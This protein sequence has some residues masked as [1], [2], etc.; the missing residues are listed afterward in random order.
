MKTI[1]AIGVVC[2]C[3]LFA[4]EDTQIIDNLTG[5]WELQTYLRNDVEETS[6]I[7][8]TDYKEI[9]NMDGTI[10]RSYIDGNQNEVSETGE[11]SIDEENRTIHI[12]DLSS[13]SEFSEANSTLSSSTLNVLVIDETEYAY[14]FENG[15]DK[16][17][18]RFFRE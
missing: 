18:F 15:G 6:D 1:T 17:E 14:S 13:I 2:L 10:S 3:A 8:I 11:Y 12:S 4:C 16:H 9:Y 7:L 5:S